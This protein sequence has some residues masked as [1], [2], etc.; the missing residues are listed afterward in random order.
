MVCHHHT[1]LPAAAI[2]IHDFFSY[3]AAMLILALFLTGLAGSFTHC[4]GMCGPIAMGQ[5]SLRLMG[6]PP[7]QMQEREKI[8]CALLLPYYFGKALTY[9]A[10]ASIAFLLSSYALADFP[11]VRHIGAALLL[12]AAALFVNSAMQR[13]FNFINISRLPILASFNK[14]IIN[15]ITNIQYQTH[16]WHGLLLGTVLGLLPCGL[17]YASIATILSQTDNLALVA[18]SMFAFALATVPGLFLVAYVGQQFFTRW[19]NA[20]K[21][22]YVLM[23]LV[24]AW[25]LMQA[26]WRLIQP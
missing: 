14:L 25:L 26:A 15:R 13:S 6:L 3:D 4:I 12:A 2:L 23:M 22:L 21:L 19:R 8:K 24:N 20:F 1:Q 7:T 16:G 10:F 11:F 17:V 18:A 9:V 5:M